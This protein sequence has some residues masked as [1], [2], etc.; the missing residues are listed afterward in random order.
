MDLKTQAAVRSPAGGRRAPAISPRTGNRIRLWIAVVAVSALAGAGY[1]AVLGLAYNFDIT[2]GVVFDGAG[3]GA[4]IGGSIG[5]FQMLYVEGHAGARLRRAPF[6]LS[7][8]I[9]TLA[10]AVIIGLALIVCRFLFGDNI[11]SDEGL[12]TM[13][14]LRDMAFSFVAFF[15]IFFVV[16]IRRIIG[17]RVFRNLI[18]GRYHKPVGEDRVFMFLDMAGSTALAQKLGDLGVHALIS[19]VFFDIDAVVV[20]HGGE[21]HRYIG[22]EVVVTWSLEDCIEDGRCIRCV[23][24]IREMIATK[25]EEYR[26]LFG[27][28]PTF[29]AGLH[30]GPVVAG[31]CGD[32]KH[33]IV[34]FGDTINTAARIQAEC[35]ELNVPLLVSGDLLGK[36]R[37]PEGLRAEPRGTT[38]LRGRDL[39]TQLFTLNQVQEAV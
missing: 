38:R 9:R 18:F 20:E 13:G 31:E 37:L 35:K 15:V 4:I 34:Y 33:E 36:I 7:L 32:S 23:F 12:A 6:L 28:V 19:R 16:Q 30:G 10:A 8:L 11:L 27:V 29:R 1:T 14:L 3:Y 5:A 17:E 39:E 21:T 2:P 24:A 26:R 22:D 25:A